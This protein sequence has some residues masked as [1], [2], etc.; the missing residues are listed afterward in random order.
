MS[1]S[2]LIYPPT[3]AIFHDAALDAAEQAALFENNW[4]LVGT[5]SQLGGPDSHFVYEAQGRSL[6]ITRDAAGRIHAFVNACTHRGTRLCA[7][8]GAGRLQCPYHGWVYGHDGRLLGASRRSGLPT[9]D[10]HDFGLRE[11]AAEELGGFIFVHG[12]AGPR[13]PLRDY[14]G[15]LAP[16]LARIGATMGTLLFEARHPIEA[17][18]KLAISGGLEDYHAP[19]VHA[20]GV[21]SVQPGEATTT[22]ASGGHSW[23]YLAAPLPRRLRV[24]L[25]WLLGQPPCLELGSFAVFPNITV[26]TIWSLLQVSSWIPIAPTR[27]LRVT[28][29][30]AATPRPA[31]FGWARLRLAILANIARRRSMRIMDEDQHI[32]N[33]AG[34]GTRAAQSHP[35]GP[36][37]AQEARVEHLLAEVAR[38]I[39]RR[40][41][42]AIPSL[43]PPT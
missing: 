43:P 25:P 31:R 10:N 13:V 39:G 37:H 14:L 11:L 24:V 36:A 41:E 38:R 17:N 23:F 42:T 1:P 35:R 34:A 12:G 33:E 7:G 19:F 32:V 22:L 5:V 29:W 28:R 21:E 27:T 40:Y 15:D 6:L 18:W 9:F 4:I 8:A 16:H 3:H 26:V 20:Q 30:F 2:E